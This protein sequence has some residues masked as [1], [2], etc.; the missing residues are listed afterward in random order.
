MHWPPALQGQLPVLQKFEQSQTLDSPQLS[1]SSA[2]LHLLR[3]GTQAS[4]STRSTP[5]TPT[6]QPFQQRPREQDIR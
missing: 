1:N 6:L 5:R 2:Q 3:S 4:A